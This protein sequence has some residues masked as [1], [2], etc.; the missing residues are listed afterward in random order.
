MV[1][2]LA[3]TRRQ[4]WL[5]VAALEAEPHARLGS[6]VTTWVAVVAWPARVLIFILSCT[7]AL[8]RVVMRAAS[9]AR[10]MWP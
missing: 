9:M 7:L 10:V 2:L 6:A 4:L 8:I 5:A 3:A 1:R